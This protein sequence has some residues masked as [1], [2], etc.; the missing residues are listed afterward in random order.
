MGFQLI[1]GSGEKE[2]EIKL[3]SDNW[4]IEFLSAIIMKAT[5][6]IIMVLVE[7]V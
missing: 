5:R 1:T 6:R 2:N 7:L 3:A 4:V